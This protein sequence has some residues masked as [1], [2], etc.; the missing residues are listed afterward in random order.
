M[1]VSPQYS[2][3]AI[4]EVAQKT[5]YEAARRSIARAR[6]LPDQVAARTGFAVTGQHLKSVVSTSRIETKLSNSSQGGESGLVR[7][8]LHGAHGGSVALMFDDGSGTVLAALDGYIGNVVVADGLVSNVSY[9]PSRMN[10]MWLRYKEER[11][12]LDSLHS[13]AAA[14][15]QFGIFRLESPKYARPKEAA[16]L[17][18]RVKSFWGVD[19]TLGLYAA[20][21]CADAGL[22]D[23]VAALRSGLR[24]QLKC[25]LFDLA[26]LV[27]A[28]SRSNSDASVAPIPFCPMLSQGWGLLRV[29]NNRVPQQLAAVRQ[30]LRVSLWATIEADGM[31]IV[32]SE[33]RSSR[34][35]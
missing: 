6:D 21:A 24:T 17:L 35:T 8:D 11:Q 29:R 2:D 32:V 10:P 16:A 13:A 1:G 19:P 30:Y 4:Q 22:A 18:D 3:E 15:A 34:L 31:E 27:G 20:Y 33:L 9:V 14:A 5:G 25:D 26:L 23:S 28:F 12:R 7:V